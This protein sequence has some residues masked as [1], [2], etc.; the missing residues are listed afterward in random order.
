MAR[1]NLQHQRFEYKYLVNEDIASAIRGF[2]SGY[3]ELDP[4]G[5]QQQN[6]SYPVHSLYLDSD[7]LKLYQS[8]ING[9][10]N[11]YKLRLRF[12]ENWPEAPVY[13]EIKRR[14][15]NIITKERCA[16]TREAAARVLDGLFPR[17]DELVTKE[18]RNINGLHQFMELMTALD[19]RPKTHVSYF[20]EAWLQP[21]SN[22][23]RVTLD[24]DVRSE[25]TFDTSFNT[26]FK[27][28][29]RAFGN[30]VILEL[31]FTDRF[32][33]WFREL[34]RVFGL[35]QGSAAKYVEGLYTMG[36]ERLQQR[37]AF[38]TGVPL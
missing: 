25:P 16:V 35:R 5:A 12:Y 21:G 15:N 23:V 3:L 17:E 10:R 20:R 31:K 24:R 22:T 33:H 18:P 1:S 37:Y 19:A 13:F 7:D 34:V 32:P 11:R 6:R 29:V 8:T 14:N 26:T 38:A 4:F 2:V 9:E 36:P 28:P 27:S 30:A